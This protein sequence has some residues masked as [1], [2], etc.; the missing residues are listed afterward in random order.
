MDQPDGTVLGILNRRV[1]PVARVRANGV[2]QP[3]EALRQ[4]LVALRPPSAEYSQP[5]PPSGNC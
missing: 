2:E 5:G 4:L 1:A 3:Q